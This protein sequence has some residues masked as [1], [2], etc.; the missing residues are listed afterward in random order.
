MQSIQ[1]T[2]IDRGRWKKSP[3][4][5][6]DELKSRGKSDWVIK[7][8]AVLQITWFVVQ[9]LFR[10][11]QGYQTTPLEIMTVAFVLCT[12]FIYA[13]SMNQPQG[14]EYP[15]ILEIGSNPAITDEDLQQPILEPLNLIRRPRASADMEEKSDSSPSTLATRTLDYALP[16]FASGEEEIASPSIEHRRQDPARTSPTDSRTFNF[17]SLGQLRESSRY[18]AKPYFQKVP[19]TLFGL[20]ACGFGVL[21]SL[22]WNS[23]F[24]T[25]QE[26]LAWRICSA[27]T[28]GLPAVAVMLLLVIFRFARDIKFERA[29]AIMLVPYVIGRITIIV[30]A[31]MALR[32]LPADAFQ[33]VDWN[34]YFPHFAA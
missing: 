4:I 14:I 9:A 19:A 3:P 27:V 2:T 28:T 22:G 7:L 12:I 15:V 29:A 1:T 26:K 11:I 23:P 18:V 13:C 20:F 10:A 33:T 31:F 24:P 25:T 30:L 8:I 17:F 32:A 16:N 21:H 34:Q 5:S 6:E